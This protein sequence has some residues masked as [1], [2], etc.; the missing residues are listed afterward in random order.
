MKKKFIILGCGNSLGTPRIDSYW[1]NCNKKNIKNFRTRCSAAV[2]KGKNVILI[3]T[4]PDIRLQLVNNNIKNVSS[5]V[6]THEH[7]DQTNGL[8]E[9]RPFLWKNN[10]VVNIYGDN[11]TIRSLRSRFDYCFKKKKYYPPIVKANI[12]KKNITIGSNNEKVY[13]Q[14]FKVKHGSTT[15]LAYLFEKIAYISDCN[16]L[17]IIDNKKLKN[18]NFLIL[19]CLRINKNHA[20]F[21]INQALFIHSILA[22]KKTI[23]TNLSY[24]LDYDLL[25]KKLPR[26]VVPAFDGLNINL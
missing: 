3:D 26:N 1:G 16:D 15:S 22:P 12:I 17:S 2:I 11:K 24:D 8:F 5:V 9:L 10:K 20:H 6:Y 19:D 14:T 7:A 18:L 25:I 13:L 23:L 4:S 21:T